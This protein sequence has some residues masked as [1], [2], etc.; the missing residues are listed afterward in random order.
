MV[1]IY[2]K[3]KIWDDTDFSKMPIIEFVINDMY[4][5]GVSPMVAPLNSN[6]QNSKYSYSAD[7]HLPLLHNF[8]MCN[9]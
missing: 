6:T 5:S 4:Y 3:K 7:K 9:M 8:K 1:N 2:L